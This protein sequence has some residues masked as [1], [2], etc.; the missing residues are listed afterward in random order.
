M[1]IGIVVAN[2]PEGIIITM[3]VT[4]ALAAKRMAIKKVLIKNM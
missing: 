2:V 3:T 1:M 4:L